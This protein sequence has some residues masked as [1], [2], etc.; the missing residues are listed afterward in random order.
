MR[1]W[2][3]HCHLPSSHVGGRT[4]AEQIE[5][6]LEIAARV[7]IDRIGVFLNTDRAD[8]KPA[9]D[10][11]RRALEEHRGRVFGF[12][13]VSLVDDPNHGLD[14]LNRWVADGPMVGLKL[15]GHSGHCN[16]AEYDPVFRRAVDLQAVIY[17][18]TWIKL[19]GDPPVPGG[20]NLPHESYP[21]EVV[22]LAARYPE[23]PFICGH[24]GGD[25]ELGIA[26][27][28]HQ[29]NVLS[30]IGGGY[31]R[32]GQVEMAVRELG[33]DHVIY[34]SDVT[35]RSFSTQLAKVHGADIS[36][37]DKQLIFNDNLQRL[38]TP[39]CRAKGIAL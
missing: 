12:V 11:I 16:R 1:I 38:M 28:R 33:A 18:H 37:A 35:G 13:W 27:I 8:G 20:G 30:E 32:V 19:G 31:P 34:G 24:T 15:G 39:I 22:E 10:E 29:K 25:W 23:Y 2:D 21:W 9:D 17:I 7:G 6:L 4:L 36:E 26:A 3:I 5:R 14:K